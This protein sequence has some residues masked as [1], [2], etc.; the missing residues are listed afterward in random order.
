MGVNMYGIIAAIVAA[1]IGL[2]V[3]NVYLDKKHGR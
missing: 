1:F 3:A 2:L